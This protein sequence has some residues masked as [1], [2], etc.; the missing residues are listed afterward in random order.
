MDNKTKILVLLTIITASIL[1]S[2]C[3]DS[4]CGDGICQRREE[5]KGTCPEDCSDIEEPVEEPT[6]EPPSQETLVKSITILVDE[7]GGRV[8]WSHESDLIAFSKTSEDG[9]F[10]LYIMNPDGTN[11]R[12][13]TSEK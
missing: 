9:Y 12:C 5:S 3:N 10:D 6:S 13:L 1:L 7:I 11:Q 4:R 2:G 8:D